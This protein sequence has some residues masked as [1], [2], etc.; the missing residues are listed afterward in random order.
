MIDFAVAQA[1]LS[2]VQADGCTLREHLQATATQTGHAHDLLKVTLPQCVGALWD[3]FMQLDRARPMGMA[4]SGIAPSDI[5]TWA[6]MSRV[7]LSPWEFDTL[8]AI[9][10]AMLRT[11]ADRKK[12]TS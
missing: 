12:A 1:R 8:L 2:A 3:A 11:I 5:D 9:D 7:S 6:R 4:P 10:G